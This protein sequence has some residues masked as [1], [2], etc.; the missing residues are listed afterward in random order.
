VRDTAVPSFPGSFEQDG[1][2]TLAE[3]ADISVD[4]MFHAAR[5]IR[6]ANPRARVVTVSPC[7]QPEG[8]PS[9]LP[10]QYGIAMF[11]DMIYSRIKSG[12]FPSDN[13]D[14]YF[15]L[16]AWHPYYGDDFT[17][18]PDDVWFEI[19]NAAYRVMQKYGDG[20][21]KVLISE[22]GFSDYGDPEKERQHAEHYRTL[23]DYVRRMPY[24]HA[25]HVFRL[26]VDSPMS[27]NWQPGTFGGPLQ[28]FFGLFR[29]PVHGQTPRATALA[30]QELTGSTADLTRFKK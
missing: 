8:L 17:A 6:R 28:E 19:H 30:I 11:F 7:G 26:Y 27:E 24:I 1:D 16:L 15:D 10:N 9:F 12:E 2:F 3:R 25:F 13:P 22:F 29:E 21:K 23:F 20:H 4:M 5:G 18:R 14:D